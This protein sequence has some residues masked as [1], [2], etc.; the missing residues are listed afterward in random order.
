MRQGEKTLNILY[1]IILLCQHSEPFVFL[2]K[3]IK[4]M[5]IIKLFEIFEIN[6]YRKIFTT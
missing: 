6:D 5:S 4:S 3:N 2:L 1:L